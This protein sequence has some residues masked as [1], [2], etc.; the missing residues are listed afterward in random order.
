MI[1]IV[2]NGCV[3]HQ[4]LDMSDTAHRMASCSVCDQQESSVSGVKEIH[5]KNAVKN[6]YLAI[7]GIYKG[8]KSVGFLQQLL[9]AQAKHTDFYFFTF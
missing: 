1:K 9:V 2:F 4:D 5:F 8:Q 7:C 3:I 6:F